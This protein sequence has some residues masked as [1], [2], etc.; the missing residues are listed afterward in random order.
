MPGEA[1]YSTIAGIPAVTRYVPATFFFTS[2]SMT[3][4]NNSRSIPM[5]LPRLKFLHGEV[6]D[7][8]EPEPAEDFFD[9]RGK[10]GDEKMRLLQ[11]KDAELVALRDGGMSFSEIGRLKGLTADCVRKAVGRARKRSERGY[12]SHR[13][14]MPPNELTPLQQK[15][16]DMKNAGM[17]FVSI[18]VE[19]NKTTNAV[20]KLFAQAREKKGLI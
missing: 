1:I 14:I 8:P 20:A 2:N 16:L 9:L 3:T 19:L 18:G 10:R 7:T 6:A 4:R 17:T 11:D 13:Y 12:G 5:T 15:V